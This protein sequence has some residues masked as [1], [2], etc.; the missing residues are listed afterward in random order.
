MKQIAVLGSTGSIGVSS[1]DVIASLGEGYSVIGLCANNNTDLLLK[2]IKDFHPRYAAVYNE[3]NY[4]KI[5]DSVPPF[6]K[7][8]PPGIDSLVFLA[9]LQ[10]A[11]LII[12]GLAG[13]VG[14][15]PLSAAIK[16]GKTIALA[17]KEP[18]VMAGRAL[19]DECRRWN[20]TIIPVDS[21]PSAVFQSLEN[22]D[23]KSYHKAEPV[24]ERVLLT[25]SGGPFFK[26]EGSLDAVTPQQALHHP[27]WKMGKKITVD[28]ATLMNKGFETIEIMHLFELPLHKIQ[29]VIHPQSI[30]HSAVEYK[31]GSILAELSNPD[32]RLPIQYAI[33]Y[34]AR[35][36]SPA[37]RLS[38][39]EMSKLEF[40]E[41]DFSKFPCLSLALEAAKKGLSY[42]AVL[43]GA[44]EVAV[45]AF[46]EGRIL[47][48]DIS[49]IVSAT[50]KLHKA[51]NKPLTLGGAAEAN[52]WAR[53]KALE[54]LITKQ[55]K[56]EII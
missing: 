52:A 37:K 22:V 14:F 3:E 5:K 15:M 6:T 2:Q 50:L 4:K 32:M 46:L 49:K 7:L 19:M 56:K 55:Y 9:T 40:A 54:L 13:S 36:P 47:F 30:V 33:T 38:I 45:N 34:P 23:E 27:R 26:Y 51:E 39:T 17:N 31:D 12:D 43:N 44:D 8:L 11:D 41:P 1:L 53:Q 24:I 25:A 42:P 16:A 21:E 35:L 48:T 20:A 10:E 18:I 28:S 29:I